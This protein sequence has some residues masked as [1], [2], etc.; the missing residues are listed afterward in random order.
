MY[1]WNGSLVKSSGREMYDLPTFRLSGLSPRKEGT[2]DRAFLRMLSHQVGPV[3]YIQTKN[4]LKN[5]MIQLIIF[6]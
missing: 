2:L 4:F 3:V 6:A 5:K 1:L